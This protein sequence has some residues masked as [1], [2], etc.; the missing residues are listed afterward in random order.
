MPTDVIRGP[1]IGVS[2]TQT[3]MR[4]LGPPAHGDERRSRVS[5]REQQVRDARTLVVILFVFAP[6]GEQFP[7]EPSEG[8]EDPTWFVALGTPD[9]V[10]AAA[11]ERIHEVA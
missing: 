10:P 3:C 5:S 9:Q 11:C 4:H 2:S 6:V 7:H 8:L 1:L